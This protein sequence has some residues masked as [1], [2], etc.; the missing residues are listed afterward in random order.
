MKT[1]FSQTP[2][3]TGQGFD[4]DREVARRDAD[5]ARADAERRAGDD[6]AAAKREAK[7]DGR[8]E[9]ALGQAL[10]TAEAL[11]APA[12]STFRAVKASWRVERAA[13][14]G[15][16]NAA[17]AYVVRFAAQSPVA[18]MARAGVLTPAQLGAAEELAR[19]HA[20]AVKPPR[21]TASYDG[22]RGVS[23]GQACW[24]DVHCQAWQQ[25][26]TGL[27]GLLPIERHVALEVVVHETPVSMIAAGGLISLRSAHR[28]EGAI[29]QTLA[30]ALDRLRLIW[31]GEKLGA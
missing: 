30:L 29:T 31:R 7:A 10:D 1:G 22:V 24:V 4:A 26:E 6:A 11:G 18:R 13:T 21:V 5:R 3:P 25:L 2:R 8:F 28:S 20:Q 14:P 12:P 9:R 15:G 16:S 27:A 17:P 23:S 19:L